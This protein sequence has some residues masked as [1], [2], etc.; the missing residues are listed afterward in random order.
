MALARFRFLSLC[1]VY[2]TA[3]FNPLVPPF[4]LLS[5]KSLHAHTDTHPHH[6]TTAPKSLNPFFISPLLT[7]IHTPLTKMAKL[8]GTPPLINI[9]PLT[10]ILEGKI[11]HLSL[12]TPLHPLSS[13]LLQQTNSMHS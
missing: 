13:P 1:P 11:T 9:T 4:P 7:L 12:T 2:F 3:P 10:E 6:P 8:L 5:T